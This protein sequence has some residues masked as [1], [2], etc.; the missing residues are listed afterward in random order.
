MMLRRAL[1]TRRS[2]TNLSERS[3]MGTL[4]PMP[5]GTVFGH[6]TVIEETRLADG[7]RANGVRAMLCR[8]ECGTTKIVSTG[9][10]LNGSSKTCGCGNRRGVVPPGTVFGRWTVIEEAPEIDYRRAMLCECE[11]GKRKIVSL[12]SLRKNLSQSCGCIRRGADWRPPN[13]RDLTG[14]RF[15][16]LVVVRCVGSRVGN[17]RTKSRP[18]TAVDWLCVCD[19]GNEKVTTGGALRSGHTVSCGCARHALRTDRRYLF[20]TLPSGRA[21]RNRVLKGYR[22][23]AY[24]RGLA[25]DLTDEEFDRLISQDCAYCGCVPSMVEKGSGSRSG[26]FVHGGIDRV[27]NAQG[28]FMGNV[29]PCCRVCNRAKGGMSHAEYLAWIGRL[30]SFRAKRRKPMKGSQVTVL[31]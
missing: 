14:E 20:R 12:H 2:V 11:C 17:T 10:L 9:A 5:P 7:R 21:G 13:F 25:W 29:V 8:C 26:D 15:G 30:T 28:Y 4:V 1:G 3:D 23:G 18:N 19:C 16:K 22:G 24:N 27:D 6:L 31:F